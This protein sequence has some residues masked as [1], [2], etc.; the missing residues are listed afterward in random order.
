MVAQVKKKSL[1]FVMVKQ[2]R[3]RKLVILAEE[4]GISET[5]VLSGVDMWEYAAWAGIA[6]WIGHWNF[7]PRTDLEKME[8]IFENVGYHTKDGK[9]S[10]IRKEDKP[11]YYEYV[12]NVPYGL[13]DAPK[14]QEPIEKTFN[15]LTH[16]YFDGKLHIRLYK[17]DLKKR[18]TYDT[19]PYKKRWNVPVGVSHEGLVYHDFDKIPHMTVAGTTRFGKSVFMKSMFT[20]LIEHHPDDVEIYC[21][22]LKGGLEFGPYQ[23]LK[24]VKGFAKFTHEAHELLRDIV[25]AGNKHLEEYEKKRITN[26]VNSKERRRTFVFVDEGG[27]LSPEGKYGDERKMLSECQNNLEEIASVLGGIGYR[28]IYG[29]QYPTSDDSIPRVVKQ[30][31]DAKIAFRCTTGTASKVAIDELGAE[32]LQYPGR[33]IYRTHER[34]I[35]HAPLIT[36]D[37]MDERLRRYERD[38]KREEVDPTD[39]NIVEIG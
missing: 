13:V 31:A 35:V 9:P 32:K 23:H 14:L 33:M 3:K 27:K 12:Y 16:I 39:T 7:R 34:K 15:K 37:E 2:K 25:D 28:L 11:A 22:D 26:I 5:A 17:E 6:L 21:I 24:Q 30:M 1:L 29:T 36:E 19:F 8:T 4:V 38:T 18:Y 10:L 20:H